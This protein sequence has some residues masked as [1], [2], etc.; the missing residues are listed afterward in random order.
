MSETALLVRGPRQ[1]CP[2]H[3]SV[4]EIFYRR[5][6]L[7][8]LAGWLKPPGDQRTLAASGVADEGRDDV[9]AVL[10]CCDLQVI[11]EQ[12][13]FHAAQRALSQCVKR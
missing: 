4:T 11:D 9:G 1:S 3:R 13:R 7:G 5:V 8:R 10:E 6:F 12:L 2:W